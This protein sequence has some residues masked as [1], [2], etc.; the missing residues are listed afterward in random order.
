[1]PPVAVAPRLVG[2]GLVAAVADYAYL[3]LQWDA[4]MGR[5]IIDVA[6]VRMSM[7]KAHPSTN[8]T[9][10]T[11][12]PHS[13][14]LFD[15]VNPGMLVQSVLSCEFFSLLAQMEA[16]AGAGRCPCNIVAYARFQVP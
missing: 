15:G 2:C 5:L 16:M 3:L 1:M 14:N 4:S 8:P 7:T 6:W 11:N 9:R 12:H 10:Q 13:P